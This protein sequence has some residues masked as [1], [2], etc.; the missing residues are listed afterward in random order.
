MF[1]Q[2]TEFKPA[3]QFSRGAAI[4]AIYRDRENKMTYTPREQARAE[5]F[6][7]LVGIAFPASECFI[8]Y[9]KKFIAVK[10]SKPSKARMISSQAQMFE[11][12]MEDYKAT[13]VVTET[14]IVYRVP[15][16]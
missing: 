11:A 15:K 13:K 4:N 9:R 10:I 16:A 5:T 8:N 7:D 1:T 3:G 14:S 2:E 6:K 12:V